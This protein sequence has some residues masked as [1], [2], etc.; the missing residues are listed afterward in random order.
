MVRGTAAADGGKHNICTL[1]G[2]H[3]LPDNDEPLPQLLLLLLLL[4]HSPVALQPLS[5]RAHA[6]AIAIGLD[7]LMHGIAMAFKGALLCRLTTK[8]F[9]M[10]ACSNL[11]VAV[12]W[13]GCTVPGSMRCCCVL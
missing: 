12:R 6:V 11:F 2:S 5:T 7:Y 8:T 4:R 13:A 1:H 10:A 3:Q 9:F